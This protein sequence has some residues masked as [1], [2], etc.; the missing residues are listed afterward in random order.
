MTPNYNCMVC[1]TTFESKIN[2]DNHTRGE[3]LR[4]V[5]L[6]DLEGH[7]KQVERMDGKFICPACS[8]KFKYSNK[9][10]AHWKQCKTKDGME[11]NCI[12]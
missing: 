3:C 7:I 10:M 5:R 4:F 8:K 9:V 2:R 11:S 6:V 1:N 12:Y